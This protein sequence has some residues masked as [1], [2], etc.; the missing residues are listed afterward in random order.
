MMMI[1]VPL[2]TDSTILFIA[3]YAQCRLDLRTLVHRRRDQ[4]CADVATR[5]LLEGISWDSRPP[6]TNWKPKGLLVA[7]LHEHKGPVNR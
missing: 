5:D 7:H 1:Y 6:P 2:S 4:Y 3:R